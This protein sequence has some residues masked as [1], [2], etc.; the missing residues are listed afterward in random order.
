[1]ISELSLQA[2]G[3]VNDFERKAGFSTANDYYAVPT[4]EDPT[5]SPIRKA[6]V[7]DLSGKMAPDGTLDWDVP[8]GQWM[9][10]RF[11]ASLTGAVNHGAEAIGLE[12]DKLDRTAGRDYMRTYLGNYSKF[13]APSLMG[14]HG[15]RGL[16]SDSIESGPQ[17]WTGD[18]IGQF[19]RL[20]GYDPRPWFPALMGVI[21]QSAAASDKFLW[22]FRRTIAE[23]LAQN[24][25]PELAASAHEHG[26]KFFS[27]ALEYDR[28]QLGDDLEMRRLADVPSGAMWS[29]RP[30]VGPYP[31]YVADQ[32]GAASVAHLYGQ[33][34]ALAESFTNIVDPWAYSARDLKPIADLQ[35]ALGMNSLIYPGVGR[36]NTWADVAGPWI[37]YLARSSYLLQQGQ[38]V[39]D[40]AYFYGEEAP[41]TALALEGHL[42]DIPDQGYAFD[43]INADALLHLLDVK[44][45]YLTTPS[46]MH[47]RALQLGGVSSKMTLPVLRRLA[48]LVRKGAIVVG[49]PPSESPSLADDPAEF[50]ALVH[51]LWGE[52][53][54][55][56][57]FGQ[58]K[59]LA[60]GTVAAALG[61]SGLPP[62]FEYSETGLNGR[63]MFVHRKLADGDVYFLDNR[64]DRDA[65]PEA[66]FRVTGKAPEFWHA[67]TG[68]NEPASYAIHDGGTLVPLHLQPWETVFVVFRKPARSA[69]LTLP[70]HSQTRLATLT[71][72]WQLFFPKDHGAPSSVSLTTLGSWTDSSDDGVKYFSG[73]ANYVNSVNAPPQ[74]FKG[75]GRLW[76]DLGDLRD[77]AELLVNGQHAGSVWHEPYRL[78]VTGLLHPGR[79]T[80]QVRVTNLWVNRMIGDAQPATVGQYAMAVDHPFNFN[81]TLGTRVPKHSYKADA[82]L[83]TSGLLGPV[84]IVREGSTAGV[85]QR[86]YND[87]CWGGE[88]SRLMRPKPLS[89][90]KATTSQHGRHAWLAMMAPSD[91]F[92]Q[93]G[94]ADKPISPD[95][96]YKLDPDS[97]DTG[98][99]SSGEIEEAT[100]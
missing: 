25:Y 78:E 19:Q 45:G 21:V 47:Y 76:I 4:P 81:H 77:T 1:L 41:L 18:M 16:I 94:P 71:G 97:D 39:A 32:R 54:G 28:P 17:N 31:T 100:L 84:S 99:S 57:Q 63:I 68:R 98:E 82:P 2:E 12:V 73:T 52:E 9:V 50:H 5:D 92:G 49:S 58:G 37:S 26:L 66:R 96:Q 8:A 60:Q 85:W 30:E 55:V 3:R 88:G 79:N 35:F 53:P 70:T 22:D 10:L 90:L 23:L 80:L 15:V 33:N 86:T 67:E 91:R 51:Q 7:I 38:F 65:N 27:Q 74:W 14:A 46:G 83:R 20:R 48:E 72:P 64:N 34:V 89:E 75:K 44:D 93:Q 6:E 40:V 42:G 56:H 61:A 87:R 13:L 36:D 24:L 43:F 62:D 11:G 69:S 29:Y 59:V 95:E